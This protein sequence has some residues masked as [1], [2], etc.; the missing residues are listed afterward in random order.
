MFF[1]GLL[2]EKTTKNALAFK[3]NDLFGSNSF[4]CNYAVEAV[5][6]R[7]FEDLVISGIDP[8]ILNNSFTKL[9]NFNVGRFDC[10]LTTLNYLYNLALLSAKKTFFKL[11]F[12]KILTEF[13]VNLCLVSIN[14][15]GDVLQP[16]M[17]TTYLTEYLTFNIKTLLNKKF[18]FLLNFVKGFEF[19]SGFILFLVKKLV[20]NALSLKANTLNSN[21]LYKDIRAGLISFFLLRDRF[22]LYGSSYFKDKLNLKFYSKKIDLFAYDFINSPINKSLKRKFKKLKYFKSF[23]RFKALKKQRNST[24]FNNKKETLRTFNKIGYRRKK[25]TLKSFL[26]KRYKTFATGVVINKFRVFDKQG[27]C[28]K[29]ISN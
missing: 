6:L 14:E 23:K 10:F 21:V 26:F 9:I 15:S 2:I 25:I 1:D 13:L 8:K 4:I 27:S 12:K 18:N 11:L 5:F 3:G 22:S 20:L 19:F 16:G 28:F 7:I 24:F 29:F 17:S